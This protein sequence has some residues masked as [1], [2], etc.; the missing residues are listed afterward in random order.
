MVLKQIENTNAA[1]TSR[2]REVIDRLYRELDA[3]GKKERKDGYPFVRQAYIETM[4][5]I[6][7]ASAKCKRAWVDPYFIYLCSKFSDLEQRAW[8]AIRYESVPLYP[9]FPI[10]NMFV[11]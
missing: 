3:I 7:S 8:D 6:I 9:Q 1:V 5:E 11:D 2:N 4:P 10:F